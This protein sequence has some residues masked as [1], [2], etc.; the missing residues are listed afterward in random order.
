MHLRDLAPLPA[1]ATAVWMPSHDGSGR[2]EFDIEWTPAG[3]GG[4]RPWLVCP[5]CARHVI[6]VYRVGGAWVCRRCGNLVYPSTRERP[7]DRALRKAR[8]AR[9]RIGPGRSFPAPISAL[10]KPKGMW[11]RTYEKLVRDVERADD[12]AVREMLAELLPSLRTA[13]LDLNL[14]LADAAPVDR[15]GRHLSFSN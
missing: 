12:R 10:G 8:Q 5:C 4:R 13:F 15:V 3:F 2:S 6:A 14:N 7:S 9:K 1:W 11:W